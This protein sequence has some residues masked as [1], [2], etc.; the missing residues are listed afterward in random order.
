MNTPVCC[1]EVDQRSAVI[2]AAGEMFP[3]LSAPYCDGEISIDVT[4]GRAGTH[5]CIY[6]LR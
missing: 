2:D 1:F 3:A 6:A 5:V 4:V